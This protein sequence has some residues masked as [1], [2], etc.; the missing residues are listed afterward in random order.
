MIGWNCSDNS[1]QRFIMI[2]QVFNGN[3]CVESPKSGKQINKFGGVWLPVPT[4]LGLVNTIFWTWL[5][6]NTVG[7]EEKRLEKEIE[8]IIDRF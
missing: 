5:L 2:G 7:Y 1:N 4:I 6:L 8:K 3:T